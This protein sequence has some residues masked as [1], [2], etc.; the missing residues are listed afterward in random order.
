MT[1]GI[2]PWMLDALAA[3]ALFVLTLGPGQVLRG[4]PEF[5]LFQVALLL[6]LV[7]RRAA[8]EPVFAVISG[9]ALAQWMR[10]I[11]LPADVALLVALYT[12]GAHAPWRHTLVAAAVTEAGVVLASARWAP[13][14]QFVLSVVALSVTVAAA[15]LSGTAMRARRAY[16]AALE[17]DRDRRA[18][19]ALAEERARTAREVHDIVTHNLSVMIA[20]ADSASYVREHSPGRAAAAL[21]Q[22][23]RTGRLALADMQR[24][25]PALRPGPGSGDPAPGIAQ[26]PGL[27]EQVRAAGLPVDLS[28]DGDPAPVP[29]LA[30]LTVYRIVQ[31][32]LTNALRHA[33]PGTRVHADV[34]LSPKAAVIEVTSRTRTTGGGDVPPEH[35]A[36]HGGNGLRAMRERVA[37]YGG[38]LRAG[39]TPDGGWEVIARLDLAHTP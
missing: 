33:P 4:G 30:Q 35:V 21:E 25:L 22:I 15:A 1:T 39:P 19:L 38:S 8:P 14:G 31:E 6:P 11:Q 37:A 17:G 26:L 9:V 29:A 34:R 27:A 12:V 16:V 23:S 28:L 13:E 24:T 2:R 32:A 20:L 7:W 3:A 5:I 18:R 36:A 10:G